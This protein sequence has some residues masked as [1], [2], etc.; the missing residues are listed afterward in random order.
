MAVLKADVI[1]ST[2]EAHPGVLGLR[3]W[4]CFMCFLAFAIAYTNR[5]CISLAVVAMENEEESKGGL[6]SDNVGIILSSF[7]WGFAVVQV[8]VGHLA[9]IR[10]AKTV[11]G[12]GML[13]SGIGSILS[14]IIFDNG[15]WMYFVACRVA[16]GL[17][18]AGLLPCTH[19]LLSKWV[20]PNERGRLGTLT[21]VGGQFGT[22]ITYPITGALIDAADWRSVFYFFGTAAVLW[23]FVIFSAGSDSPAASSGKSCCGITDAERKYIESGLGIFGGE[24]NSRNSTPWKAI[25]TSP[26]FW[27]LLVAHCGQN[28]GFSMLLT[29]IPNYMAGVLAFDIKKNGINSA[30]PYLALLIVTFPVSWLS[31]WSEKKGVSRG[32]S[33]KVCNSIGHWG[34]GLAFVGICFV[35]PGDTTLPVVLLVLA[36]ALNIGATCGFQINHMD[37]S[38]KYAG[39]L[40]SITNCA[41]AVVSLLVPLVVGRIVTEP[42]NAAQWEIV[43]YMSAGIYFLANLIF[44]LFGSG[45]TQWWNDSEHSSNISCEE[46]LRRRASSLAPGEAMV[47]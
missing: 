13:I 11:L 7:Y 6:T 22:V 32:V 18:Q 41:A 19:T 27:A 17:G 25:L 29:E 35:S 3:H 38:L 2:D 8:P 23:S 10:S 37:L 44:I 26:P 42:T 36:V 1:N 9:R 14:P 34:P 47:F 45:E 31:D 15:H 28:W 5:V 30:L 46:V 16:I 39:L 24:E 43:F 33:R 4:Q 40:A 20:P 21:Y 12:I